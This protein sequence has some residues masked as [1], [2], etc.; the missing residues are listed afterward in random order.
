MSEPQ[1]SAQSRTNRHVEV[2]VELRDV[3]RRGGL[4]LLTLAVAVL[5]LA[6]AAA[7][8]DPEPD[9]FEGEEPAS[10]PQPSEEAVPGQ[11]IVKYKKDV[12]SS[13]Q[14]GVRSEEGLEKEDELNLINAEV[15]KVEG[16]P[17]EE[18]ISDL[19]DRPEVEYAEP[20]FKLYAAGYANEPRFGELWGLNNTGQPIRNQVGT[21]DIDVNGL[22]AA[23]I[24]Q[25][26]PNLVVAVIDEGVD[27]DHPDL[28]DNF[29]VNPDEI[30]NNGLDD[31]KNGYVD[32]VHGWDFY[33]ND[34][35]IYD[36]DPRTES[37]DE[38]G[39]HV[40][41]TIAAAVNNQGVVGVA[42]NV[43]VM[44][45]KFLGP[46]GVGATSN[47]ILAIE[48]AKAEGV[49]ISNN[50]WTGAEYSQPLKEAIDASP[51]M[52]FVAAAGNSGKNNDATPHYPASYDSPNILSVAAINNKGNL[53]KFSNYGATSVDISAPGVEILST[54]PPAE[55]PDLPAIALSSVG[56]VPGKAVTAGFGVEEIGGATARA[57]FMK[58]AFEAIGRGSQNIVLVD[59]DGVDTGLANVR[60]TVLAAI[61]SATGSD[62]PPPVINVIN[63]PPGEAGPGL[64]RLRGNTVVWATGQ[65]SFSA[66]NDKGAA[67]METLRRFLTNGGKLVLT[68]R[69]AL[70][71]NE[72]D[73]FV[74][75]TLGL[76]VE[77]NVYRL[78][79]VNG[80]SGTG[81]AEESYRLNSDRADSNLHDALPPSGSTAVIQGIYIG[82]SWGYLSGTSMATP[83]ATGAAALAASVRPALL[84]DP[85]ALKQVVV[86]GGKP[87]P[88][89]D[90]KTV[91]GDMVDAAAVADARAPDA[92]TLDLEID[93]DTGRSTS[94]DITNINTPTL[95]GEAEANSTVRLY[96][97]DKLLGEDKADG[98]ATAEGKKKWSITVSEALGDGKHILTAN[99][100][101]AVGNVSSSPDPRLTLTIDTVAPG[102]TFAGGIGNNQSFYYGDVP[103]EPT[104]EAYDGTEGTG[105]DGECTVSGYSD[106]VGDHTMI[107][108][109][110]D[111][112]GNEGQEQL[113]YSVLQWTVK[114]FYSPVDMRDSNGNPIVNVVNAGS[115]VPIKFEVFKG[116]QELTDTSSVKGLSATPIECDTGATDQIEV[117]ATGGTA[118]GT[119]LR[120]DTDSGQFNFNWK[121]PRDN[122]GSCYKLTMTTRDEVSALSAIF[123]LR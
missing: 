117:T 16:Q 100:R 73:S 64:A 19:N 90:G 92:P 68:G 8:Q 83:H 110:K 42:P 89:T 118:L 1:A 96:E 3:I 13:E 67:T 63:V 115:A 103:P 59:D 104:C 116:D 36:P 51:G 75:G 6:G 49:K 40:A 111:V 99:A 53:A 23:G 34:A 20:D 91:T 39:T 17:V 113:S 58:K 120:Y 25:G 50:S 60:P 79:A 41:G 62:D 37:G 121:T 112:A 46:E 7:A 69:D 57:S 2:R 47:G 98:E 106:K 122:A 61:E 76:Q 86:D 87:L 72:N 119:A 81:F 27:V 28:K 102:V 33:N 35:S 82:P 44:P 80:S 108:A 15:V 107:G 18:A 14:A 9:V 66:K 65:A 78:P 95:G 114:G 5:L 123:R 48:Y 54:L 56:N 70:L 38:H 22:E 11:I 43:K 30:P 32:D 45:L 94:D 10:A 74:T 101:D 29:W 21:P 84:G 26:D 4:L 71:G 88:A 77:S 31:D 105:V 97:G 55:R 52:L 93:S 85:E 109:A 24:T 12:G